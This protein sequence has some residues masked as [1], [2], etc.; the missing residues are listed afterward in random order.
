M[1]ADE[2][3]A[4]VR[5]YYDL[6]NHLDD[7]PDFE[8]VAPDATFR[9]PGRV[10]QGREAFRQRGADFATAFPDLS[11]TIDDLVVADDKAAIRYT[12]TATHLGMFGPYAATGKKVTVS[13]IAI[14]RVANGQMA[15]GWGC[16]DTLGANLQLGAT[17]TTPPEPVGSR[18]GVRQQGDSH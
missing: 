10:L 4:V 12:I 7:A 14:H 18:A 9:E 15:E 6:L 5:C 8:I 17:L 13:G 16:F 2:T 11:C 3:A 1:S